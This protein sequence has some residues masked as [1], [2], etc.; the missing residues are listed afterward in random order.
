MN[1]DRTS[2][3]VILVFSLP[4]LVGALGF[5]MVSD[6]LRREWEQGIDREL[7][8]QGNLLISAGNTQAFWA[9]RFSRLLGR[10][11]R[12][13]IPEEFLGR[14]LTSTRKTF[15]VKCS[16]VLWDHSRSRCLFAS[17]DLAAGQVSW[18]K[19]FRAFD[20]AAPSTTKSREFLTKAGV[21]QINRLLGYVVFPEYLGFPSLN[22]L[23]PPAPFPG[24]PFSW[25]KKGRSLSLFMRVSAAAV[26]A[27]HGV[28]SRMRALG[29]G[30]N[31]GIVLGLLARNASDA[32]SIVAT[33]GAFPQR[34]CLEVVAEYLKF[35]DPVRDTPDYRWQVRFL[36]PGFYVVLA[37]EKGWLAR[38]GGSPVLP[39]GVV[40]VCAGLLPWV[41]RPLR[42]RLF[43]QPLFRDLL[44]LLFFANLLPLL[45]IWMTSEDFRSRKSRTI[46]FEQELRAQEVLR[47]TD[48]HFSQEYRERERFLDSIV[49]ALDRTFPASSSWGELHRWLTRKIAPLD[50][51]FLL[52]VSSEEDVV[53]SKKGIFGRGFQDVEREEGF[54]R[55]ILEFILDV[56]GGTRKDGRKH[57]LMET[58]M[59]TLF[60]KPALQV[61]RDFLEANGK[62]RPLGLGA[63]PSPHYLRLF[64]SASGK[65]WK[66]ALMVRFHDLSQ[67]Y[68]DRMLPR[69]NRNRHNV[70]ILTKPGKWLSTSG[71]QASLSWE[72]ALWGR[73]VDFFRGLGDEIEIFRD[74]ID[75]E[76]VA[77]TMAGMRTRNLTD[78]YLAVLWPV[79]QAEEHRRVSG[80]EWQLIIGLNL[81][82]SLSLAMLLKH[83]FLSPV[84]DLS[85]GI[86]ALRRK[87]FS[88]RVPVRFD[89]ELGD[90]AALF[91][92]VVEQSHDLQLA[93]IV[94]T[95]L[96]PQEP[97]FQGHV[98]VF[99]QTTTMGELGGDYFDYLPINDR[100]IVIL[101]GD[102][103]G[104]GL[105]AALLMAMTKALTIQCSHLL[106]N[107]TE[108]L[109]V[110]HSVVR[111]AQA[112]KTAR[113]LTFQVLRLDVETGAGT[114]INAG[115]LYPW[116]V[117]ANGTCETWT[118]PS[119]PIGAMARSKFAQQEIALAV[120]GALVFMTDGCVEARN[121]RGDVLGY[122]R[123]EAIIRD[124]RN[125][126][127]KVF[128]K[129]S[130]QAIQHFKEG[131]VAQDDMTMVVATFALEGGAA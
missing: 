81:V 76:G 56:L 82:F 119:L 42:E 89:N 34:E 116:L 1:R 103:V 18:Q 93:R 3:W 49:A 71:E 36:P 23:I 39:V 41:F 47:A 121:P 111:A 31:R 10:L 75:V 26:N 97:L 79:S 83:R 86:Q 130:Y 129:T 127:P 44:L 117:H 118:T 102:V 110:L 29:A 4:V 32:V 45:V 100:E 5:W 15:G 2:A 125:A 120:G 33:T 107:P 65:A 59:E 124:S 37:R 112:G 43:G 52:Y 70:K 104:H 106:A 78:R 68:L 11:E 53:L 85:A 6:H 74:P 24:A 105:P 128:W 19:L 123:L 17:P 51:D 126:D 16:A 87:D 91:N 73:H 109:Q 38:W 7:A 21:D 60:R 62:I 98:K 13:R 40:L 9:T 46:R 8:R 22:A 58:M 84:E 28:R 61:V 77:M 69:L 14:F 95:G 50:P 63:S 67:D 35:L 92:R 25:H 108:F 57:G 88:Q 54:Y 99:G 12:N 80:L 114:L 66:R 96:F 90:M 20:Q 64:P 48:G 113:F 115:N 101:V 72:M 94:Q 122:D 131:E 27:P 55:D 30:P